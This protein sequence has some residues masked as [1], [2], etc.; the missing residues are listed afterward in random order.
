MN[1]NQRSIELFDYQS[2]EY[3]RLAIYF[4]EWIENVQI[5]IVFGRGKQEVPPL[6]EPQLR[7]IRFF[8]DSSIGNL[9]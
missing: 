4:I 1:P 2:I 5:D 9:A 8:T 3:S 7:R 6:E